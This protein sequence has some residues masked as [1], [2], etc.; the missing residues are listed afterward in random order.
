MNLQEKNL[1]D[2]RDGDVFIYPKDMFV[3]I[4]NSDD[5]PYFTAFGTRQDNFRNEIL[6]FDKAKEWIVYHVLDAKI[7][8][9]LIK[10][11]CQQ[12]FF[13]SKN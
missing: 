2:L 1:K 12:G 9:E 7:N 8:P 11:L 4:N 10:K 5:N 3:L 13:K 6:L